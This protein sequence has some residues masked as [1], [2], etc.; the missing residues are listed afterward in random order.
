[1]L[2]EDEILRISTL[3]LALIFNAKELLIDNK[4]KDP[5]GKVF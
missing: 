3:K 4:I 5:F 1:M 2:Y